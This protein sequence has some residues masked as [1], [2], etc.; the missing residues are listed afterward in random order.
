[1]PVNPASQGAP[2]AIFAAGEQLEFAQGQ[3]REAI[4]V[5]RNLLR[6]PDAAIRAGALLRIA[7]C[8]RALKQPAEAV[9]TYRRLAVLGAASVAGAPAEIVA[10]GERAALFEESGQA[11]AASREREALRAILEQGKYP[12]DCPTWEFYASGLS[13]KP[14]STAWARAAERLWRRATESPKG[15]AILSVDIPGAPAR[16][17]VAEWDRDGAEGT[18][19][20]IEFEPIARRMRRILEASPISW[21]LTFPGDP[22]VPFS[23]RPAP[24]LARG[25]KETGL[26]W[27]VMVTLPP[28]KPSSRFSLLAGGLVLLGTV[29]LGTLYL[30]YRAIRREL[31]VAAMQSDFVAAVSHEFRTPITALTHLAD[32]LESGDAAEDRKPLYYKA[33]SRETRRL[34]EMV[35][36]LLDFGRVEAGRYKYKPEG[37]NAAEFVQALVEDF[38]EQPGAANHEIRFEA[39]SRDVR[40]AVDPEVMR[41][42]V[43]NLLDNSAR[44]SPA[45]TCI[46]A[47]VSEDNGRAALS[48]SDEG[49]GIAGDEQ[50]RIFQ[51][52][53]RGRA[54][55]SQAVKG[56]GIGLAMV[57]AIVRAHGGQ[58]KL[59]SE[60][61]AGSR[62]T[63]LLPVEG[64][65]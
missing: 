8:Q 13:I 29:I 5:Y 50:K 59:E 54:A 19:R 64:R 4:E 51:K 44:Y 21:S 2:A 25:A 27:N 46:T 3:R 37:V 61:G 31:R 43:W 30:A 23:G 26:P 55:N 47:R 40:V 28:E 63:I 58:V 53:V 11:A 10:L 9:E 49:P 33:L 35:E 15:S 1:L 45:G 12:I 52:F 18:G 65:T 48:I 6:N 56:T 24:T 57:D 14:E 42:A 36:N 60:P 39:G 16:R 62:F 20:L 17:F 41:R 34:R 32:M 22:D 38:R 7:R